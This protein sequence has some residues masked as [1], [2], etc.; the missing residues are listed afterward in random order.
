MH[1]S[2][3]ARLVE[4]ELLAPDPALSVLNV[5]R[6]FTWREV[7]TFRSGLATRLKRRRDQYLFL[8]ASVDP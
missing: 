8:N 4:I 3:F 5:S 6:V 2:P 1:V 7:G